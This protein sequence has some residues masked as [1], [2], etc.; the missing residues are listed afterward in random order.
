M[1]CLIN[2]AVAQGEHLKYLWTISTSDLEPAGYWS[3]V[4]PVSTPFQHVVYFDSNG[5]NIGLPI[6]VYDH[7]AEVLES[8]VALITVNA[9][10]A[11]NLYLQQVCKGWHGEAHCELNVRLHHKC[12]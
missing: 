2:T 3:L 11:G 1:S 10:L 12:L 7:D 8:S 4:Q 6:T 5:N 9:T